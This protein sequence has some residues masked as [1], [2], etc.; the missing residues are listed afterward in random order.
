MHGRT[1]FI[2]NLL[3][4]LQ[5]ATSLRRVI[6]VG[7]A[8]YEGVIDTENLSAIGLSVLAWR[9]H[10]ASC[11]TLLM[12]EAA[13]RAPEVSF[14]HCCPGVVKSGITRELGPNLK[15]RL[16]YVVAGLLGP[17]IYT[18]PS[19]CA[20]RHVFLATSARYA[21]GK[22]VVDVAD[23]QLTGNEATARVINEGTDS[24]VYS[25]DAKGECSSAKVEQLL[26]GYRQD[27]T[28]AKV[29]EYVRQDFLRI[30]GSEVVL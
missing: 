14:I 5:N 13:R 8:S 23:V 11:Q 24:R 10:T 2:L 30:T 6:R 26:H 12:E 17:L 4:L 25:V 28:A 22:A 1:R 29:W 7:A 27:G 16:M 19:E 20:E 3:P 21:P 18:S 9:D 15:I